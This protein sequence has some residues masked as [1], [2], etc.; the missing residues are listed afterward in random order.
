M[1][2]VMMSDSIEAASRS[3]KKYDTESISNLVENIV[4]AQISNKQFDTTNLTF[5]DIDT[6]KSLLK[7]KLKNIYH[8]R[9]EYPK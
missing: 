8:A 2:V 3:L 5:K 6:V 9:I 4:N 1:A 7:E